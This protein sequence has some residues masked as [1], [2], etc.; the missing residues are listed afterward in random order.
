M[1]KC[2]L[3]EQNVMF[4]SDVGNRKREGGGAGQ[5]SLCIYRE[6]MNK[7]GNW[8]REG[9]GTGWASLP[10]C[11]C[12]HRKMMNKKGI[13]RVKVGEQ[14]GPPSLYVGMHI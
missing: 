6:M 4:Q 5:V 12:I 14:V 3:N 1:K 10:L 11:I 2:G 7:V 13:G 8:K 9:G